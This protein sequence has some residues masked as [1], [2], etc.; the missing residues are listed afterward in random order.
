MNF[1]TKLYQF[2]A[3]ISTVIVKLSEGIDA[4]YDNQCAE[5]VL[6]RTRS[7]MIN[8]KASVYNRLLP[9]S[10]EETSLWYKN[11]KIIYS[12]AATNNN[13]L[14]SRY[15]DIKWKFSLQCNDTIKFGTK[16]HVTTPWVCNEIHLP[17]NSRSSHGTCSVTLNHYTKSS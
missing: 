9:L 15:P 3:K 6:I 16:N 11:R 10:C 7:C 13:F 17:D 2:I 5:I 8:Y 4:R 1:V 14:L 12:R